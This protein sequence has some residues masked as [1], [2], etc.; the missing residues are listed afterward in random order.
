MGHLGFVRCPTRK[1]ISRSLGK[2]LDSPHTSLGSGRTLS[3]SRSDNRMEVVES[4]V[5]PGQ[6]LVSVSQQQLLL[7]SRLAVMSTWTHHPSSRSS[8][9][10]RKQVGTTWWKR[11][12]WRQ[13]RDERWANS[14]E[15][16]LPWSYSAVCHEKKRLDI[17]TA[18]SCFM[19]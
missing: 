6:V 2:K 15:A 18:L 7:R 14:G 8:P 17:T 10:T 5:H 1:R 13:I 19:N 16:S 3:T 4:N 9:I 12:I 11:K